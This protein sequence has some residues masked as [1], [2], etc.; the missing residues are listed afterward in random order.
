MSIWVKSEPKI[1]FTFLQNPVNASYS[2]T[3]ESS[4][5]PYAIF[6]LILHLHCPVYVRSSERFRLLNFPAKALYVFLDF[7]PMCAT[8]KKLKKK[9]NTVA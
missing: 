3:H 4:S 2:E 6:L 5:P 8:Y 7:F 9:L 1:L